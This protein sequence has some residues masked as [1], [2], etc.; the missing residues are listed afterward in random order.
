[1]TGKNYLDAVHQKRRE[2]VWRASW[3]IV[4]KPCGMVVYIQS[5]RESGMI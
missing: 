1:M 3:H 5:V 4:A 2:K